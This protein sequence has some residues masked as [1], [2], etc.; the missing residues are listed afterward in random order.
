MWGRKG[1][2]Y[3]WSKETKEEKKYAKKEIV[4]LNAEMQTKANIKEAEWK[5]LPE[6]TA[7]KEGELATTQTQHAATKISF[8]CI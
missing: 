2:F 5:V 1:L 7:L 4:C 6:W 8:S 3:V